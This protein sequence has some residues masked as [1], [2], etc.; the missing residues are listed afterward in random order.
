MPLTRSLT[1][2]DR[3]DLHERAAAWID[4]EGTGDDAIAG[5]HL[6]NAVRYRRELGENADELAVLAGERLGEAGMRAWRSGDAGATV[7]LLGRAVSLLPASNRRGELQLE[8]GLALRLRDR[9]GEA[10]EAWA[11]AQQDA[12][13]VRSSRLRARVACERAQSALLAGDLPL[14]GAAGALAEALPKLRAAGDVRGLARAELI[15]S[16]VHWFACRYGDFAAAAARAEQ[17]YVESG[18]SPALP[19]A[20]QAEALYYG[21]VPVGEALGICAEIQ[22]R[23]RDRSAC[24]TATAVLGALRAVEGGIEDGQLLLTHARSLYEEIGNELGVLTT[25]SPLFVEVEALAGNRDVAKA[26]FRETIDRLRSTHG[27]AHA[28]TQAALLADLLLDGGEID[29]ADTYAR[30]AENEALSSDVLVQFL[31]RS[32]RA[33]VL[34]R[35]GN[36]AEAEEI[37]RDAVRIASLTDGVRD[38]AR[39]HFALAEVLH[40]GGKSGDARV[41]V[42][43]GRRL[44]RQKGAT[45]L[46]ERHR[47]PLPTHS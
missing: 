15:L 17:Y 19:L 44:L 2:A 34:G 45:A 43:M 31:W 46:L 12:E 37:A 40:L 4:R 47:T 39:A 38:R 28:T 29:E 1:K 8:R 21:A 22:E 20:I 33:R 18:F 7:A 13:T 3:A 35:A 16:N 42:T 6:E 24:A 5:Y 32:A 14:D 23:S 41:E 9:A 25:W 30:L 36:T 10:D 27:V 26:H 11:A